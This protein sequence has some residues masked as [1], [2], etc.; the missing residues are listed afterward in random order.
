MLPLK[1]NKFYLLL[2]LIVTAVLPLIPKQL[3]PRI[4][5]IIWGYSLLLMPIFFKN[6]FECLKSRERVTIFWLLFLIAVSISTYFSVNQP[7]SLVNLALFYSYFVIFISARSL[8]QPLKAKELLAE[9][10]V[11]ISV[12]LSAIS[13]YNTLFLDVV[14]QERQGVSLIW[15]YFGH[16]HLSAFLVFG[17]PLSAY[18]LNYFWKNFKLRAL[19]LGIFCF[20]LISLFF[21]LSKGAIIS[22]ILTTF[23]LTVFFRLVSVKESLV[24]FLIGSLFIFAILN[25]L[26]ASGRYFGVIRGGWSLSGRE[27]YWSRAYNNFIKHPLTGTG[28]DSTRYA[29]YPLFVIGVTRSDYAHN[30]ALQILSDAGL[31]GFCTFLI[32]IAVLIWQLYQKSQHLDNQRLRYLFFTF[33]LALIASTLNSLVDFDW[34]L[35]TISLVFW[36]LA[37]AIFWLP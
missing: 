7:R 27:V 20:L 4:T 1:L 5:Y 17:I 19:F 37:G 2:T 11:I 3:D 30:F 10:L 22:L 29:K 35:P 23:V 33:F 14:N 16:N 15:I 34:Q 13:I 28:L 18:L 36:L 31:L 24:F 25:N 12:V 6:L 8:F 9:V 32:L 26:Y 21:T